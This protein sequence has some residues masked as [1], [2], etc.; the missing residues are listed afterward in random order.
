MQ[1]SAAKRKLTRRILVAVVALLVAYALYELAFPILLIGGLYISTE[2]IEISRVT[3]PDGLVDVVITRTDAGA[4][5]SFYYDFYI[6]LKG[7]KQFK[8]P[9]L[10]G[11]G[12]G[13]SK[14]HWAAPGLLTIS[15][16]QA[17]INSFTNHWSESSS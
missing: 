13:D 2:T 3:S 17:C 11:Y 15:Y 16:A 7:S 9:I 1:S 8:K 4:L 10:E 12:L 5:E 6:V 14:M